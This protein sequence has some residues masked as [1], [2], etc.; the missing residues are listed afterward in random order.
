MTLLGR[1]HELLV[2]FVR[3]RYAICFASAP[4]L[5]AIAFTFGDYMWRELLFTLVGVIGV[6]LASVG[7]LT[8]SLRRFLS[9]V[10]SVLRS[11]EQ[12]DRDFAMLPEV[13]SRL[14]WFPAFAAG[15]I[16]SLYG[17][18]C[19]VGPLVGNVLSNQPLGRNL[20]AAPLLIA[21]AGTIVFVPVYLSGEQTAAALTALVCEAVGL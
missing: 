9:P 6:V 15:L 17:I 14:R 3:R 5:V 19:I 2:A 4:L 12:Q 1:Y 10:K 18:V 13:W 16:A 20:E 21:L 7:V 8:V 11:V